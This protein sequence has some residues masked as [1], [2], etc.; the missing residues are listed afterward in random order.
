MRVDVSG[1]RFVF[2]NQCACCSATPDC[3]LTVTA[4]R[5]RGKRVVHTETKSWDVPYC[6]R[7]IGH[8]KAVGAARSLATLLTFLSILLGGVIGFG[9]DPFLGA[10]FGILALFGT[11][12]FHRR[13][14]GQIRAE[15]NAHSCVNADKAIVYLGW[16]GTLHRFEIESQRFACDFMKANQNKLVNLS[17]EARSMLSANGASSEQIV[18]RSPRRYLS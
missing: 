9:V 3:E 18:S 10:T 5:S 14:L 2:P 4:S 12:V 7:C 13:Q 17:A 16:Q 11:V 6:V 15:C 1:H 8:V